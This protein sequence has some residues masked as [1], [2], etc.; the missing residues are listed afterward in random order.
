[1]RIC[2]PSGESDSDP[3]ECAG[4]FEGTGTDHPALPSEASDGRR[5][6]ERVGF[7]QPLRA[8]STRF[9]GFR[10]RTLRHL[11]SKCRVR[12]VLKMLLRR[13]RG[14]VSLRRANPTLNGTGRVAWNIRTYTFASMQLRTLGTRR[15][16][17]PNSLPKLGVRDGRCPLRPA[18]H[19]LRMVVTLDA[20]DAPTTCGAEDSVTTLNA[21]DAFRNRTWR[22][23]R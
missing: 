3:H 9:T 1:M 13:A 20:E 6:P 8:E 17:R 11:S 15:H 2:C 5:S 12:P 22:A 14:S 16:R 18:L 21:C 19:V 23:G 7:V 10:V 4:S